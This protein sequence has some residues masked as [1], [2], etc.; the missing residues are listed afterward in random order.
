MTLFQAF[1]LGVVQGITEFLPVSSSAHIIV[2]ER[3]LNIPHLG[4][5]F[6]I[7][8]NIG[9]LLA[10]V[11]FFRQRAWDLCCGAIDLVSG[12]ITKNRSFFLTIF[13]S[14]LPAIIIGGVLEIIFHADITSEAILSGGMI[15]FSI[16]LYFCDKNPAD[17]RNV[18]KKDSLWVGLI[19]PISFIPGVSRLGI[20]L[21]MMRYLKYS[22]EDSFEYA[23]ILSIPPVFGAFNL[24]LAKILLGEE[25]MMEDLS[26]IVMGSFVAF[27]FGLLSLSV[28]TKFLQNHT[29]LPLVLY[30]LFV[31]III[32][33]QKLV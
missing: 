26:V 20:C 33:V 2:L 17:K 11:I 27:I 9:T 13:L 25:A 18:S 23:M 4:K 16:I 21:S 12:K 28:I 1:F 5:T 8:L 19:Q 30:R 31:S 6:S 15:L 29:L 24:K 3:A 10:T 14:S 22:R 7:F 32:I